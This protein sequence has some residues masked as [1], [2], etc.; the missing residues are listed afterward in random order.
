LA[1]G[2]CACTLLLAGC[3]VDTQS[4]LHPRGFESGRILWLFGAFTVVC[5]V[6]YVLVVGALGWAV[7][8]HR[9]RVVADADPSDRV[10]RVGLVAW[11]GFIASVLFVLTLASYAVD[12]QVAT[13]AEAP[14]VKVRLTARQWWWQVEYE[15]DEPVRTFQTAN[16]LLL[17]VGRPAILELRAADVIHSF[18]VPNL[19]GKQDMIPGRVNEIRLTPTQ[20]G[21]YRGECAEFCGLQHAHMAFDVAV[22]PL[23]DFERWRTAQ[24]QSARAPSS[25]V[26]QRGHDYF[27]RNECA[28]CHTIRGTAANGRTG[29]ELTH[30]AS[31]ASLAAGTLPNGRGPLAAWLADPQRI[32]PGNHMPYVGIPPDDLDALVA[33][34]TALR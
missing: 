26:E 32:K 24:L 17:P 1:G 23:E 8:R 9:R 18:W 21:R 28:T 16:E 20:I 12:R 13:A 6:V 25:A 33:Y 3:A 7:L 11:S 29:P 15:G 14:F 30:V 27:V 2:L 31:R 19:H 4:V 5:T 22:V 34:L 10:L